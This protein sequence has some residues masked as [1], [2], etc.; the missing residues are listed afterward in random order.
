MHWVHLVTQPNKHILAAMPAP[1]GQVVQKS[2][3]YQR[4][5]NKLRLLE[6]MRERIQHQAFIAIS[7]GHILYYKCKR[8]MEL[9]F[10]HLLH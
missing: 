5:V 2:C 9:Q 7:C 1:A 4:T 6:T 8:I 10:G 3:R